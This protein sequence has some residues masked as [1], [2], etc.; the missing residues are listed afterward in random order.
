QLSSEGIP[1]NMT[2]CFTVPQAIMAARA[3]ARYISP[4]VG[5]F[6]DIGDEGL[7]HLAEMVTAVKNYTYGYW[8]EEGGPEIITA[9]VRTPHHVTQAALLGADIATVPFGALKKCLKHPLTDQ[10]LAS[11]EA[12]W[13]KV[14]ASQ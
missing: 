2:L 13:A 7:D 4:F 8:D 10:G 6:D 9:S 5:R 11:F 14:V 3:G 12:D 1:V